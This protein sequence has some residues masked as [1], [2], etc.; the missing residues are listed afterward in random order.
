[1]SQPLSSLLAGL[2]AAVVASSAA[3]DPPP[4]APHAAAPRSPDG[5]VTVS[6]NKSGVLFLLD[7][8]GKRL[9]E[10]RGHKGPVHAVGFSP[11]GHYLASGG[12]DAT[13]RLWGVVSGK[14]VL[15]RR[16]H[17]KAIRSVAFSPDGRFLASG[18]QGT[19]R[20]WELVS[21]Q[22]ALRLR[23]P[24]SPVFHLGFRPDGKALLVTDPEDASLSAWDL[25]TAKPLGRWTLQRLSATLDAGL[26]AKGNRT[27]LRVQAHWSG[28]LTQ[29]VTR[30]A[31]CVSLDEGVAI[32]KPAGRLEAIGAGRAVVSVRYLGREAA[33]AVTVPYAALDSF[34]RLP[35]GNFIDEMLIAEWKQAGLQPAE[36]ASD[37]AF[38]RRASLHLTG[39]LP[40]PDLVR[41]FLASKAPDRRRQLIDSLLAGPEFVDY[42]S[43][44][45][46]TLL[47]VEDKKLSATE[48]T[49]F[50]SWIQKAVR[51][52]WPA[53]RLVRELLLA[54]GEVRANGAAAFFLIDQTLADL[55]ES[56]AQMFL[57]VDLRCARCHRHP[58]GEWS[59]DDHLGLSAFFAGIKRQSGRGVRLEKGT[60]LP[61]P[62]TGKGVAPSLPGPP[63]VALARDKDPREALAA[64]ITHADN[65]SFARNLVNR[66]WAHL[67][68]QGLAE[69]CHDLHPASRACHAVLLDALARD[70]IKNKYDLKHLL[71][72][73]CM[74]RAYQLD[75][76]PILPEDKVFFSRR[77]LQRLEG[78]LLVRAVAQ[79]AGVKRAVFGDVEGV[80]GL[81]D[82]AVAFCRPPPARGGVDCER[83]GPATLQ[84]LPQQLRGVADAMH[85]LHTEAVTKASTHPEGRIARL[86]NAGATDEKIIEE[87]FLATLSHPVPSEQR[88][89]ALAHVSKAKDAKARKIALED[90][91]WA[92]MN[93]KE[94][95]FI[96]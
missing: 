25:A 79:A 92:L 35:S 83:P 60:T 81:G 86:L 52:N 66:Y 29:D 27:S 62:V 28:G 56:T 41:R 42:W 54:G 44:Q 30:W 3:A 85:F 4:P 32:V 69:P 58:G 19:V 89:A 93:S 55:A 7:A 73:I 48:R 46:G 47:R 67:F 40:T 76:R 37:T 9:H 94:F 88:R 21:G 71:R 96:P 63:S 87:L 82:D 91:L 43:H 13:V 51:E 26:L 45:W 49:S 84:E 90:V 11:D 23:G 39:S 17:E 70:F 6:S 14:E 77:R 31:V 53:D 36:L 65:L 95:L 8:S 68:G 59:R 22:E 34:P 1:V 72:T 16:G 12:D 33:V 15:L 64:W 80:P 57:G 2:L 78:E 24:T 18:D 10:L 38:L 75:S 20:L 5:T 50:R 74:S 61:H